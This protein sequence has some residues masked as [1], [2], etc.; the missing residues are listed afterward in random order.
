[1]SKEEKLKAVALGMATVGMDTFGLDSN[2]SSSSDDSSQKIN[3]R[4]KNRP[5]MDD[6]QVTQLTMPKHWWILHWSQL[7]VQIFSSVFI[8]CFWWFLT[9]LMTVSNQNLYTANCE[10]PYLMVPK[11]M[12]ASWR[13]VSLTCSSKPR[14]WTTGDGG[15]LC[16]RSAD[17][18]KTKQYF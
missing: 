10:R 6:L 18:Y 15:T 8:L 2:S 13:S 14:T 9:A 7:L 16:S 1:M 17:S 4:W 11:F 12:T 3:L 5:W